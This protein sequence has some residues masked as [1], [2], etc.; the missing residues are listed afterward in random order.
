MQITLYKKNAHYVTEE[1]NDHD[2]VMKT[3]QKM[4]ENEDGLLINI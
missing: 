4:I 3:I 1:D 2:G